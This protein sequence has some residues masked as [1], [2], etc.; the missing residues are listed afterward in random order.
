MGSQVFLA[1][2][3]RDPS[4]PDYTGETTSS[5][6]PFSCPLLSSAMRCL[7]L[8]LGPPRGFLGEGH[9]PP[10]SPEETGLDIKSSS[11]QHRKPGALSGPHRPVVPA[12]ACWLHPPSETEGTACYGMG[13]NHSNCLHLQ[14]ISFTLCQAL[15]EVLY[16]SSL[17]NPMWYVL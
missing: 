9:P 7:I 2:S 8:T 12:A 14:G 3:D 10:C 13:D 1:P 6:P 15:F 17:Q 11:H 4:C 16:I 5:S